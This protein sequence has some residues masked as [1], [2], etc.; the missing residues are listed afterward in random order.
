MHS[1]CNFIVTSFWLQISSYDYICLSIRQTPISLMTER[2]RLDSFLFEEF[3][4]GNSRAFDKIFNDHYQNLC[5]FAYSIVHDQDTAQSLVQQV[6]INLWETRGSLDNVERLV[7]YFTAMVRNQCLNFVRREKRNTRLTEIPANS[8]YDNTTQD[9]IDIHDFEE[10]LIIA[11]TSLPERCKMAFEYS[12]FENLTNREI[13]LKMDISVKGVEA[14]IGRS[15]KQL[16]VLLSD[17]LPAA[18]KGKIKD[19][20]LIMLL[21][22]SKV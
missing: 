2:E 16:R 14:L 15:L 1:D 6:F 9:Q 22:L 19:L 21:R 7:P 5:R 13:A 18:R 10:H 3:K 17:Y 20:I 8:H 12:R 11:L 4:N